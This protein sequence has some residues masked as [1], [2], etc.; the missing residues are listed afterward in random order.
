[1]RAA[2]CPN[3]CRG[4]ERRREEA[5]DEADASA[6]LGALA[7]EVV[8]RLLHLDLTVGVLGDEHDAVGGDRLRVGEL[9]VPVE[10]LLREV[11]DQVDGDQNVQLVVVAHRAPL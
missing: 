5:D 8:A 6:D 1:M 4:E 2:C 11:G 10:V 9:H 3:R 7:A